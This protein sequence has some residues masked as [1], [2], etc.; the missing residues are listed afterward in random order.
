MI[1][2]DITC[3][4]CNRNIII[5]NLNNNTIEQLNFKNN[6]NEVVKKIINEEST[7]TTTT[8]TTLNL[9]TD[10]KKEILFWKIWR[11]KYILINILNN[12][13][14]KFTRNKKYHEIHSVDYMLKNNFIELLI[15]KVKQ[16]CY[17]TF[18]KNFKIQDLFETI[19]GDTIISNNFYNNLI[20]NYKRHLIHKS[21]ALCEESCISNNIE[22]LKIIINDPDYNYKFLNNSSLIDLS[23]KNG[24]NL[25]ILKF[26]FNNENLEISKNYS[27]KELLKNLFES[28][29]NKNKN[30]NEIANYLLNQVNIDLS[31]CEP[32]QF[33]TSIYLKLD[34]ELFDKLYLN[35]KIIVDQNSLSF[36][37]M[38]KLFDC[39]VD[40]LKKYIKFSLLILERY[41]RI[42]D[43]SII[44]KI[45]K[46]NLPTTLNDDKP[47]SSYSFENQD[48]KQL[49]EIYIIDLQELCCFRFQNQILNQLEYSIKYNQLNYLSNL[50]QKIKLQKGIEFCI[51]Y[52]NSEALL[53]I[54]SSQ[55]INYNASISLTPQSLSLSS[56]SK[57]LKNKNNYNNNSN[58]NNNNNFENNENLK[59][60]KYCINDKEKQR[61]FLQTFLYHINC[62]QEKDYIFKL[63]LKNDDLEIIQFIHHLMLIYGIRIN[64]SKHIISNNFLQ[65]V[66]STKVLTYLCQNKKDFNFNYQSLLYRE[67]FDLMECFEKFSIVSKNDY[68]IMNDEKLS[69]NVL[70]FLHEKGYTCTFL[71]LNNNNNFRNH[72]FSKYIDIGLIDFN[73][74]NNNN[75]DELNNNLQQQFKNN[76]IYLYY[77][78]EKLELFKL[79]D[80]NIDLS[81]LL[82]KELG[83]KCDLLL[84]DE[85]MSKYYQNEQSKTPTKYLIHLLESAVKNGHLLILQLL[86]EK[87][88]FIFKNAKSINNNNKSLNCLQGPR[89]VE[90]TLIAME[91][92]YLDLVDYLIE[93]IGLMPN[94]I[95]ILIQLKLRPSPSISYH[96]NRYNK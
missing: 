58:N 26:L 69:K 43:K 23:I 52:G 21:E 70:K 94:P 78:N 25:K 74:N 47:L 60:F 86:N 16:N 39:T 66:E 48:I 38:D 28:K 2:N 3:T 92:N 4:S 18:S 89:L 82:L 14:E 5:K 6:K 68:S 59:L 35:D 61:I 33:D 90:L 42:D 91:N 30:Y 7:T 57:L 8:T 22:L 46:L 40:Q 13:K 44:E 19:N 85:F 31:K 51:E 9:I 49:I 37:C 81:S 55:K 77:L 34:L 96:L 50:N 80:K 29:E 93:S 45:K 1:I 64:K 54:I 41:L 20:K 53:E 24:S 11:N 17:L 27:E 95:Q 63:A 83:K 15:D 12:L 84:I 62:Y 65:F 76:I 56:S 67:R 75:D 32:S 36:S 88:S 10:V 71:R 73:N 72:S 87:Y 79:L